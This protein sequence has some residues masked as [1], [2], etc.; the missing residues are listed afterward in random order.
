MSLQ[1]SSK[2]TKAV[3]ATAGNATRFLPATK[4]IPKQ[5]LPIIDKPIIQYLVEEAVESGIRD[6][7]IVTQAG[8]G[9]MEDHFD[10]NEGLEHA[11]ESRGKLEALQKIR[12]ITKLANFVYVRQKKHLPY[13]NGTPL[14]AV[15]HLIGENENF[16]YMFGDDMTISHNGIPVTKQLMR[17]FEEQKPSAVLAVQEV[18]DSEVHTVGTVKYKKDAKYQYEVEALVEKAP[19]GKNPS[20][21]GQFGRFVFSHDV[22]D[23]VETTSTGLGNELWLTDVLNNLAHDGKKVIAQPVDGEWLTTGDPANFIKTTLKYAMLRPDLAKDILAFVEKL[24]QDY[25]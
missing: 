9:A 22:I 25:V 1:S 13:G 23:R 4:N 10:N 12:E 17:V 19:L 24:K 6:I 15:K 8:Q 20:N 3:I 21:M 11:L 5:M 14:I 7:I 2:I 18:P 16:V